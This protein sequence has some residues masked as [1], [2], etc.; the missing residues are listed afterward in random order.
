MYYRF[1]FMYCTESGHV[2]I[3]HHSWVMIT[4]HL[5]S[6][7]NIERYRLIFLLWFPRPENLDSTV[8]CR[9]LIAVFWNVVF[10]LIKA[11]FMWCQV[12]PKACA[13][14]G[15]HIKGKEEPIPEECR[16]LN[17]LGLVNT[18]CWCWIQRDAS[19]YIFIVHL[20]FFLQ[21][22]RGMRLNMWA[23]KTS[24]F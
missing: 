5:F 20:I 4:T 16:Q 15:V 6:F 1:H 17:S 3:I 12:Y 23:G 21:W 14:A 7:R 22:S 24:W 13:G 8:C 2:Y 9:L 18:S 19:D 11:C 10:E